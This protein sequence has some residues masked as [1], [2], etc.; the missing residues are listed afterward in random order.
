[1]NIYDIPVIGSVYNYFTS[2]NSVEGS[3][4][5][6]T[7]Q[8][9]ADPGV[10]DQIWSFLDGQG[11]E[12]MVAFYGAPTVGL[13]ACTSEGKSLPDIIEESDGGVPTEPPIEYETPVNPDDPIGLP[14]GN[15]GES[16]LPG[17]V[18]FSTDCDPDLPDCVS[19]GSMFYETS[20]PIVMGTGAMLAS[21]VQ[22]LDEIMLGCA[23]DPTLIGPLTDNADIP[24][25][26]ADGCYP[27][28]I[29]ITPAYSDDI[30]GDLECSE[31]GYEEFMLCPSN[32]NRRL[33]LYL[34]DQQI[35]C[36][37]EDYDAAAWWADNAGASIE[38]FLAYRESHITF[39]GDPVVYATP[40]QLELDPTSGESLA[41]YS[42][43]SEDGPTFFGQAIPQEC[44][45]ED[46]GGT[47]FLSAEMIFSLYVDNFQAVQDHPYQTYL[48]CR[49]YIP[50][51][52]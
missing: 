38:D 23:P 19:S 46:F 15:E 2:D 39:S 26:P 36:F 34:A 51:E 41:S 31:D 43:C 33:P 22:N 13:T 20:P 7:A 4:A 14:E 5:S 3:S 49:M 11:R 48:R 17:D 30:F 8:V 16:I 10:L 24:T 42:Y 50:G 25:M 45:H 29:D 47:G 27:G 9:A 18:F 32:E 40:E 28:M 52:E 44:Y 6:A 12:A 1:M 37:D 21:G 35:V